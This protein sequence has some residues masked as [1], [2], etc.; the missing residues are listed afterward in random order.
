M[1]I[2]VFQ[3]DSY[4]AELSA[5]VTQVDAEWV[6][7]DQTIFY[8]ESGGQPGDTGT[9]TRAD[10][11]P[12]RVVDTK[13]GERPGAIRHQLETA[14]HGLAP[15]DTMALTID[16][17]RRHRLMR[18]HTAM[19][20]LGSL[21]PV[22]VTGGKVGEEKS[23]L[24]FNLGDHQ[25]DKEDLTAQ[26]NALVASAK[27]VGIESITE[28]ELDENPGLVRTMSVQPPRGVGDIRMIR[29]ADIDYQPCG[30]T[31]VKNIGEI[32]RIR[33]SKIENKGRQNRRVHL[34]FD[35]S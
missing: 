23:R 6:E 28:N 30:G 25:I 35:D 14:E 32:G 29:V 3:Q 15:G 18:M 8:A 13:K 31:H 12:L 24:D 19:H 21:I 34:I 4:L 11:S 22:P 9:M 17:E 7:L 16:W 33:V 1:T 27:D 10:G 20:L 5:R 26:L 2:A